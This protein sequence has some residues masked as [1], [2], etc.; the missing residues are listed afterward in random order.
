VPV[1]LSRVAERDATVMVPPGVT[2][3]VVSTAIAVSALTP[4]TQGYRGTGE[5]DPARMPL[6]IGIGPLL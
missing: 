2:V 1:A 6:Q 5:Q 4:V 3:K